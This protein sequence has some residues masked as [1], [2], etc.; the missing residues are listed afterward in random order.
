MFNDSRNI[1]M[2]GVSTPH[3]QLLSTILHIYVVKNWGALKIN[4]Y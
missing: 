2:E 1:F 3:A 4:N